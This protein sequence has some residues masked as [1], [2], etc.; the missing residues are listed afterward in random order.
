[1]SLMRVIKKIQKM[2]L[3]TQGTHFHRD[4]NEAQ[5]SAF[6]SFSIESFTFHGKLPPF[7]I[8]FDLHLHGADITK[9][10]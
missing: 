10:I 3:N 2:F 8:V 4:S 6:L 7:W 1:M 9:N 5:L